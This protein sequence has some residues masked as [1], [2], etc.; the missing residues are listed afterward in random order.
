MFGSIKELARNVARTVL[1]PYG[2]YY[3]YTSPHGSRGGTP[4]TG[5]DVRVVGEDDVR[6]CTDALIREQLVYLGAE[7]HAYACY[8]EGR[9]AGICI[10]WFG[11]RYRKRNFW[12]LADGEAK[13]VQIVT[14]PSLRR[15]GI[16]TELI[17]S[18]CADMLSKGFSRAYARIWHSN[19]PSV[20]AFERAGW[21]RVAL[22]LEV[23]P[24]RLRSP[25]RLRFGAQR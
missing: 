4:Q 9:I 15:S 21:S 2:A 8:R 5:H 12:P 20:R 18:S 6:S 22:V 3:V 24:L 7:T 16:A 25:I 11:E 23:N 10:Y 19:T 13:L 1:G 14:V 17:V